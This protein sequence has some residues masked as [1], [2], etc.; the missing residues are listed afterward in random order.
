[1]NRVF[2]IALAFSLILLLWLISVFL[3]A[4]TDFRLH[5][6]EE[7]IDRLEMFLGK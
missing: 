2:V 4:K 1:M 5:A 3:F 7:R 6:L